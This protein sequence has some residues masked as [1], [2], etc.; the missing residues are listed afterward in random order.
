[1][2]S[3]VIELFDSYITEVMSTLHIPGLSISAIKDNT[4]LYSRGFGARNLEENLPATPDTLYGVGSVTKSFTALAIMQLVEAGKLDVH[5]PVKKYIPLK[6]GFTDHPI[7]IFH[8]LTHSSGIPNLGQAE[9]AIKRGL[10]F[11]EK[12]IPMTSFE[13]FM[14]FVNGA[15]EEIAAKPSERF[16]YFNEGYTMLGRIIEVV[17]GMNY[18]DYIR[19]KILKPLKMNRS[20]FLKEEFEADPDIMTPYYIDKDD[21]P[22]ST[23][24]PFNK[25]IYAAG[26]LLSSVSELSNYIIAN[27][28]EG[29]FDGMQI[30]DPSLLKEIHTP[31]IKVNVFLLGFEKRSYG[32]GWVILDNFFGHK[33]V[34]HSGSVGVCGAFVAF[35]PDLKTGLAIASNGNP[36]SLSILGLGVLALLIGKKPDDLPFIAFDKKLSMLAGVYESYK[37]VNRVSVIKKGSM[38]YLEIKEK[39][40]EMN[41]P[42]IPESEKL[43]EYKFYIIEGGMKIPVEFVVDPSGKIDLY[44]ERHRL[45][46]VKS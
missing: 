7:E 42:L 31:H 40:W 36:D 25:L 37:G 44:M 1:M 8:L 19:E 14:H 5:D 45:H 9:I 34:Y 28:N 15:S 33:V 12:W 6:I 10:G 46:K 2:S 38:L 13:D 4:V 43:K 41:V 26:G 20:T 17:S 22:V 18:E 32:Y 39:L 3:G 23:K 35:I 29:V 11:Y 30:V 16:F 27:M 21:K 24:F